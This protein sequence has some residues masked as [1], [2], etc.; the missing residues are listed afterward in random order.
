MQTTEAIHAEITELQR[1]RDVLP[2]MRGV[3]TITVNRWDEI[4][5]AVFTLEHNLTATQ[6]AEAFKHNDYAGTA[7]QNAI[8]WRDGDTRPVSELVA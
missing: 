8:A 6:A 4:D 7:A 2:E 5:A 1:L 3:E